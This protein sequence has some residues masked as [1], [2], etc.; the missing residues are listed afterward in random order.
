MF[1]YVDININNYGVYIDINI[2]LLTYIVIKFRLLLSVY[3]EKCFF[4]FSDNNDRIE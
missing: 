2:N 1:T 3:I 4:H